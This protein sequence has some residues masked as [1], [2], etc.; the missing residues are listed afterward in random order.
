MPWPGGTG[1]SCHPLHALE[2]A[3]IGIHWHCEGFL[4]RRPGLKVSLFGVAH[5]FDSVQNVSLSIAQST[6][7]INLNLNLSLSARSPS[8]C[9]FPL[10]PCMHPT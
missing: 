1:T 6:E 4:E 5:R 10:M 3:C 9:I 8:G 2:A 7:Y